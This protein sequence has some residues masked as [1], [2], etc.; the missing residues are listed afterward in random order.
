MYKKSE[1]LKPI[2]ASLKQGSSVAKAIR[3]V[4][5][6]YATFW[7]W[8]KQNPRLDN[9]VRA[10][11]ESRVEVVEDSLYVNAVKGNIIAQIFFLK[12]RASNRWMDKAVD[13]QNIVNVGGAG[14]KSL[15]DTLNELPKG[16]AEEILKILGSIGGGSK[17]RNGRVLSA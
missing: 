12:N 1:V 7:H 9:L 3:A 5:I 10:I 8:R 17:E 2:L 6:D 13:I 16:K 15:R 4:D 11:K 14:G